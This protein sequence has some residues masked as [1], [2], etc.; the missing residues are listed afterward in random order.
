MNALSSAQQFLQLTG[1]SQLIPESQL[2]VIL[3]QA[4]ADLQVPAD[5]ISASGIADWLVQQNLLTTWQTQKLLQ[6]KHRGFFLG[7]Y[8][9]HSKLARG[10]M[11]TIYSG[12]HI[13][14]KQTVALKVLPL[15]KVGKS[16]YLPRFMREADIAKRLE[17]PHV[18]R[19]F[20]IHSAS[21][22]VNLVHF[23][24]MELLEGRD[25]YDL[26]IADGPLP[27]RAAVS[28]IMQAAVGLQYAHEAGLVHRDVKP[29][30]LFLTTEGVVKILDLG[31]AQDFESTENLTREF[32]ERVLGTA[33]YLSPEQAVDSHMA[34]ARADIY[35]LG[36]TLYFLLTGQPP[37]NDGTLTQRILAHQTRSPAPIS[38]C[39][40]D[41]PA[42]LQEILTEMMCK[43]RNRRIQTAELVAE[44]LK[45]WLVSTENRADLTGKPK[46]QQQKPGLQPPQLLKS[47]ASL[48]AF[49]NR[50]TSL[51]ED[52]LRLTPAVDTST[53]DDSGPAVKPMTGAAF[54]PEFETFL[55]AL[56][57]SSGITATLNSE[58]I[59]QRLQVVSESL[60]DASPGTS[61]TGTSPEVTSPRRSVRRKIPSGMFRLMVLAAL[62]CLMIGAIAGVIWFWP[63][64]SSFKNGW[65]A[66]FSQ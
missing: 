40:E 49:L 64:I 28:Y 65:W 14:S 17:H 2:A 42:D 38:A 61:G 59:D 62:T 39:R 63:Q 55:R 46:L 44:R 11:S 57:Q 9:L 16:S 4:S 20:D 35:S 27:C 23:M 30:N 10:G 26:V 7:P 56:N 5:G 21:D 18:V 43:D 24:A 53:S 6:G 25:L 22:G 29:G 54:V 50:S 51:S 33:D 19:V 41:V 37:F 36:C 58:A 15:S 45:L 31:L 48:D 60:P 8:K 66:H 13:Q 3:R 47:S 1:R 34:D 12:V 32:N 52:Q